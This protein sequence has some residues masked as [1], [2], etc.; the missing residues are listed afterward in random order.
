MAYNM[1][2]VVVDGN[3]ALAVYEVTTKARVRCLAGEGPTLLECKTYRWRGHG[4]ADHQVYQPRDEIAAWM[5]RCPVDKLQ[6]ELLL[7]DLISE[8][9]LSKIEKE[10]NEAVDN[11]VRFA[12][13]SPWPNPEEALEDVYV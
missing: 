10:A 5:E 9:A 1:P 3:D 12:E 6:K 8:E 13:E 11:A 2:G 7:E 4:E